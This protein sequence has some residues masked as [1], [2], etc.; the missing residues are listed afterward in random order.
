MKL[1]GDWLVDPDSF[2]SIQFETAPEESGTGGFYL[3]DIILRDKGDLYHF[4]Q[5]KHRQDPQNLWSWDDLLVGKEGKPSLLK[6]WADSIER[7]ELKEKVKYAGLVTDSG[8]EANIVSFLGDNKKIDIDAIKASDSDLFA[9]IIAAIG[10]EDVAASFFKLFSFNFAQKVPDEFEKENFERFYKDLNATEN[11]VVN[12]LHQIGKE[13]RKSPT[14]PISL[15]QLRDWCEFDA[16]RGLEEDF[17][18]PDDFEFFDET[19]HQEILQDLKKVEGGV[20]VFTGNPGTGKS[21]YLSKLCAT[22]EEKEVM[23][24]R[25]HYHL[26]P[27]ETNSQERLNAERVI[28]AIKAQFKEYPEALGGL[29]NKNSQ[30]IPPREFINAAASFVAQQNKTFVLIIDGLD[31]VVRHADIDELK[32]FLQSVCFPQR[33]LWIVLGTQQQVSEHLPLIIL[34]KCPVTEWIKLPGLSTDA[35]DRIIRKNLA[36]I[37]IPSEE[38]ALTAVVAK[39]FNLTQGNPLHLRYVLNEIKSRYGNTLITEYV[40]KDL[41]PYGGEITSYYQALWSHLS[42]EAKT[43]LFTLASVNFTFKKVQLIDCISKTNPSE[44]AAAFRDIQHLTKPDTQGRISIYHNSFEV[45]LLQQPDF[46]ERKVVLKKEIKE[47]LVSCPYDSLR[48]AELAKIEFETGNSEPILKLDKRWLV[49]AIAFP[50]NS[51][52][53]TELLRLGT[54]AAFKKKDFAKALQLSHLRQYY[55]NSEDSSEEGAENIFAEAIRLNPEMLGELKIK[56]LGATPLTVV[57]EVADQSGS[58]DIPEEIITILQ[59][60]HGRQE[61]RNK[62]NGQMPKITE[63]LVTVVPY[64]RTHKVERVVKYIAQFSDLGW[65][66]DLLS[67]YASQLLKLD[68]V[69]KVKLLLQQEITPEVVEDI[70]DKCAKYDIV[71]A[72]E[73]FKENLA[74]HTVPFHDVYRAVNGVFSDKLPVLPAYEDL[75]T[76]VP[77]YQNLDKEKWTKFFHDL[78]LIGLVYGLKGEEEKIK[79]W[80][81]AAPEIWASEAAGAL[82]TACL[83]IAQK[84]KSESKVDYR[85]FF[86]PLQSL[87]KLTWEADRDLLG[88]QVAFTASL[89]LSLSDLVMLKIAVES[90]HQFTPEDV[91]SILS[92]PFF[93]AA[94]LLEFSIK[95]CKPVFSSAAHAHFNETQVTNLKESVGYFSERTASFAD[96]AT[97]CRIQG[98]TER[99]KE[100]LLDSAKNLLGYGYHK[101]MYLDGVLDAILACGTAGVEAVKM[102]HWL[103]SIAPIVENVTEYTDGDGT[104]HL[105]L[106]LAQVFDKFDRPTLYKDYYVNADSEYLFHA[107]DLFEVIVQSSPYDSDVSTALATTAL[108]ED[109]YKSLG[110][111]AQKQEGAAKALSTITDYFGEITY[112]E[113]DAP[114]PYTR[115]ASAED[116]SSVPPD[117]LVQ[118]V[119]ERRFDSPWE[120]EVYLH[121]WLIYWLGNGNKEQVYRS[122]VAVVPE[123]ELNHLGGELLDV[124]YPLAYEFNNG[125]AFDLLCRAQANDNGW[126]SYW[127]DKKKAEARWAFLRDKYPTRH[128]EFFENSIAVGSKWRDGLEYFVPI[129]RAVD[130]FVLFGDLV[131]A[132][133]ITEASIIFADSLMAETKLPPPIWEEVRYAADEVDEFDL[134]VQ[135]LTWPSPL[136]RE[137]AA[138]AIAQLL[139]SSSEREGLYKKFLDKLQR[140]PLESVVAIYLLC[141]I[142]ASSLTAKENISY[143]KLADIVSNLKVNSAVIQELLQ[144]LAALLDEDIEA[145]VLPPFGMVSTAPTAFVID[146]FFQKYIKSFLAPIYYERA[147]DIEGKIGVGFIKQ[148]AHTSSV[149]IHENGIS[150][151][152]GAGHFQGRERGASLVGMSTRVSEAYRSA[153]LR[154]LHSFYVDGKIPEDFYLEYAYATLPVDLGIWQ[155]IMGRLP[156]W[157]PRL[158]EGRLTEVG[159]VE[160]DLQTPVESILA[161][162][163]DKPFLAFEGAIMPPPT[164]KTDPHHSISVIGFAYEV[165]GSEL[166]TAEEVAKLIVNNPALTLIPTHTPSPFSFLD[167]PAAC[168][169]PLHLNPT[170]IKDLIVY[171]LVAR[172]RDLTINLWQY[173]RDY[174]LQFLPV[175]EIRQDSTGEIRGLIYEYRNGEE[176]IITHSDWIEGLKERNNMDMPLPYG[177]WLQIDRTFLEGFLSQNGLR[178][179]YL[180]QS[181]YRHQEHGYGDVQKVEQ[182]RLLNVSPIILPPSMP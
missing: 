96:L 23:S 147:K 135:R 159:L 114:T 57:A 95:Q 155:K 128:L 151:N 59:D 107:E 27:E 94:N 101:D 158:A 153:F 84:I 137:R 10:E 43:I 148:W 62:E 36:R 109:S 86:T 97:L 172:T 65:S 46:D 145:I 24:V 28:E 60:R 103:A 67:I 170:K 22:L 138:T 112:P 66:Q 179:G 42:D 33:G 152:A 120:R 64:D 122:F 129:A 55:S 115:P 136:V 110:I 157:W 175:P 143:I 68:Q 29:A 41:L 133:I 37:N 167:N 119:N 76:K 75:P 40:I 105:S 5:V 79:E 73:K 30:S 9:K 173:F 108:D 70:L 91:I 171:P 150:L 163:Q 45:F 44:I 132:E 85:I 142:R 52:Q 168:L 51:Y 63:A 130:F 88:L 99:A 31:H 131:N 72:T 161:I 181:T 178:M 116:F 162:N 118:S 154:V 19:A 117:V 61:Y 4:Y 35:V 14:Q 20:K 82:L 89:S 134:V 111:V 69:E 141:L 77:E 169:Y 182:Y 156:A 127:T 90:L 140:A 177:Q 34:Q 47:W 160:A 48:W 17:L 126:Q 16:P 102:R 121:G 144:E 32:K 21:V 180:V 165:V 11:G 149:L 13:C 164:A 26:S 174:Q 123:A 1:C 18:I 54:E 6:K 93:N 74:K 78:F 146:D 12:L 80:I 166:P 3:D 39:I 98:D 83:A 139:I 125:R 2:R 106:N 104:N 100:L 71:H 50:R 113:K 56:D 92:T 58:A 38:D 7:E 25:H 49:E 81:N 15:G 53:I 8:A 176:T 124:L 87:R